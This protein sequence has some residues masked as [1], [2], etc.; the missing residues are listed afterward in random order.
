MACRIAILDN[1]P[2]YLDVIRDV[3]QDEGFEVV[4]LDDLRP[5]YA[6]VQQ[7]RPDLVIVDL[8]QQREPLGLALLAALRQDPQLRELPVVVASA[9]EQTLRE[10]AEQFRTDGCAVL[11][12]P[13]EIEDL[14]CL[15]RQLLPASGSGR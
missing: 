6:F 11:G 14:L 13:F 8:L 2:V 9:D 10:R 4:T 1:E 12:K 15:I 3:L 7:Q 5:G